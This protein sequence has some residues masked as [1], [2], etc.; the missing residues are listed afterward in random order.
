MR[1]DKVVTVTWVSRCGGA[2]D[3]RAC[4]LMTLLG[5]LDI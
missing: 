1:G 4:L 2:K 3:E 5:H